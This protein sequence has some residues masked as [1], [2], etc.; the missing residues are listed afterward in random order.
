MLPLCSV[1]VK[2]GSRMVCFNL[3]WVS[4]C[5]LFSLLWI[6]QGLFQLIIGIPRCLSAYFGSHKGVFQLV[7]VLAW[8]V[9]ADLEP[10]RFFSTYFGPR[11]V[12]VSLFWVPQGLLQLILSLAGILGL[13]RFL[14]AYFK[15]RSVLFN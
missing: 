8:F 13:A 2:I 14:S 1:P 3:F 15:S 12:V 5:F 4:Q 11:R 9:S 10:L 7:L 6:P